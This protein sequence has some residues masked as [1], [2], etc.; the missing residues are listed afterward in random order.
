[1][2]AVAAMWGGLT[3]SYAAPK[4]P[5]S[6][7]IMAFAAAEFA[8][9]TLIS[10]ARRRRERRSVTVSADEAGSRPTPASV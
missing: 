10:L 4:L 6:F 9:A 2:L 8:L 7:S 3:L 5:A 1:V